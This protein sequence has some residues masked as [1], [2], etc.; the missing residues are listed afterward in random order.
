MH[1]QVDFQAKFFTIEFHPSVRS[2]VLR[3][4]CLGTGTSRDG[5]QEADGQGKGDG[6]LHDVVMG[7]LDVLND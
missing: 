6:G 4:R 1:F 7:E 5:G 3:N 2:S